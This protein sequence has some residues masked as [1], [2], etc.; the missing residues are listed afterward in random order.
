MLHSRVV[1]EVRFQCA[2]IRTWIA[3]QSQR[4]GRLCCLATR[5][6]KWLMKLEKKNAK[7]TITWLKR[8]CALKVVAWEQ[9]W[10]RSGCTAGGGPDDRLR[11]VSWDRPNRKMFDSNAGKIGD[12]RLHRTTRVAWLPRRDALEWTY[13]SSLPLWLGSWD[14]RAGIDKVSR[15]WAPL[16]N[17]NDGEWKTN[18]RLFWSRN[19]HKHRLGRSI[20]STCRW[21]QSAPMPSADWAQSGIESWQGSV[22]E[23]TGDNVFAPVCSPRPLPICVQ[24]QHS[25]GVAPIP[26]EV[27][28]R[29]TPTAQSGTNCKSKSRRYDEKSRRDRIPDVPHS[30]SELQMLEENKLKQGN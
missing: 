26:G 15:C 6:S 30:S 3:S 7:D 27:S 16:C 5:P 24:S 1:E 29:R 19:D 13:V 10:N 25:W 14:Y 2:S 21:G 11:N 9:K 17:W 28:L 23:C 20:A 8:T 4:F 22:E 18:W 12:G